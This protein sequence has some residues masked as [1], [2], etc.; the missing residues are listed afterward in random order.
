VEFLLKDKKG[1]HHCEACHVASQFGDIHSKH[2]QCD[3]DWCYRSLTYVLVMPFPIN[4]LVLESSN[5]HPQ[6]D[7]SNSAIKFEIAKTPVVPII[8]KCM[9]WLQ[10]IQFLTWQNV[11][12]YSCQD[13]CSDK[14][15]VMNSA[16]VEMDLIE[17][18]HDSTHPCT[19]LR[20]NG[21]FII[22]LII[23]WSIFIS[24]T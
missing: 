1:S 4:G 13:G 20:K 9:L 12:C 24:R 14:E 21:D 2:S 8:K 5:D 19:L 7:T 22:W 23:S 3:A 10:C 16:M 15:R 18:T 17:C 6:T 11:P